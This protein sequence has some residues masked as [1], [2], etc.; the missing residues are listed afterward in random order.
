MML[1]TYVFV[2]VGSN[3]IWEYFFSFFDWWYHNSLN[4]EFVCLRRRR[5]RMTGEGR[6]FFT[7]FACLFHRY[8]Y[9]SISSFYPYLRNKTH[10]VIRKR[11]FCLKFAISSFFFK[12][13]NMNLEKGYLYITATSVKLGLI[14][15]KYTKYDENIMLLVNQTEHTQ[16][17][18]CVRS[19]KNRFCLSGIVYDLLILSEKN[20]HVCTFIFNI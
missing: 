4:L 19:D 8:L 11:M 10:L 14:L 20:Y 6:W 3:F 7:F 9:Y 12:R 1:H 13:R 5:C 17:L 2:F 16:E 18:R 15:M